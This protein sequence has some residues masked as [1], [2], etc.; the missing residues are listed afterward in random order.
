M[1]NLLPHDLTLL[2]RHH[3][4]NAASDGQHQRH[5]Q[6]ALQTEG[7]AVHEG[8]PSPLGY[9]C[10]QGGG[11]SPK[12]ADGNAEEVALGKVP[13]AVTGADHPDAPAAQGQKRGEDPEQEDVGE[14][15]DRNARI[16]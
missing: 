15:D 9:L 7:T 2:R 4:H 11:K 14:G 16:A 6:T 12:T 8:L 1:K 5:R 13:H 10:R 3:H